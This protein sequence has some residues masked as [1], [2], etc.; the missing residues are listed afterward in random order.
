M[1]AAVG[2]ALFG[3]VLAT[4]VVGF[5]VSVVLSLLAV[6]SCETGVSA[7]WDALKLQ[8]VFTVAR[9][10]VPSAAFDSTSLCS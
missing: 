8:P 3:T 7:P 6:P 4:L 5:F 9:V 1:G 2:S 10:F